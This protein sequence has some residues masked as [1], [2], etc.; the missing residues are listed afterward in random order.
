MTTSHST[1]FRA[2]TVAATLAFLPSIGAAQSAGRAALTRSID[3]IVTAEMTARKWP[4]VSVFLVRGRDTVLAKAYGKADLELDVPANIDGVYWIGSVTKQFVASMVLRLVERGKVNLDDPIGKYV[5]ELPEWWRPIPLKELA[6]HTSGIPNYTAQRRAGVA[7]VRPY[8]TADSALALARDIPADFP[9]G[10]QMQ[11]D[12][13]GYVLLGRVIEL[14]TGKALGVV[15]REEFFVPL[16]L[17]HTSYCDLNTVVPQRA[18]GYSRVGTEVRRAVLWWPDMAHGAGGICGSTGDLVAWSRAL[19][20]GKVLAPSSYATITAPG[21]LRDGTELRYGMGLL[22]TEVAGRRAFQHTGGIAGFTTW[23]AYL[24]DDSVHIAMTVNLIAGSERPSLAG[25]KIVERVLGAR[26]APASVAL[27]A[28]TR[29]AIV[30]SYGTAARPLTVKEEN[31]T[32]TLTA[33]GSAA[34]A[35]GYQGASGGFERF[36]ASDGSLVLFERANGPAT[37]LRIDGGSSHLIHERRP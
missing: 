28:A 8:Y 9:A 35:L 3:S 30:G 1:L 19:H 24:P 23:L 14:V 15:L 18:S 13:T 36:L 27:P 4:S 12:N 26:P 16:G 10:T 34:L 33:T 31:G 20:S 7:L 2:A 21:H 17:T 5:P 6:W 37:R 22:R 29:A 11:Y 25:V 32:L